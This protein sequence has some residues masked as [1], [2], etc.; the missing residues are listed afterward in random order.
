MAGFDRAHTSRDT[1]AMPLPGSGPAG[2]GG[3]ARMPSR[4][5]GRDAPQRATAA[6]ATYPDYLDAQHA[7]DRLSD[8][9]FPVDRVTIVGENV[10]LVERVLGR[11]TV[12]RAALAG[13]GTGAWFGLLIGVLLG[14]FTV[15]AWWRVM[16]F[17]IVAGLLWGAVFGAIA[18][19]MTGGRRDFASTSS[20]QA[21]TYTLLVEAELADRARQLLAE[22]GA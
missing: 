2:P 17:A 21:D 6:V 22:P 13:A 3:P 16:L 5:G 8:L 14:I 1:G 4:S 9:G 12:G 7:V 11:M 20:L 15:A 19:A 10:R 18:H